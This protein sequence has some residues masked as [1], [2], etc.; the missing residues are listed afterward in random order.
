MD[1]EL[2]ALLSPG[3]RR[4]IELMEKY[5]FSMEELRAAHPE[6]SSEEIISASVEMMD[7]IEQFAAAPEDS[8]P[9]RKAKRKSKKAL[10]GDA[11]QIKITLRGSKPPIWRRVV[12]PVDIRL[13]KLHDVIQ[14]VMG[15]HNGHLHAFEIDGE[16]Y[17][18]RSLGAD[19]DEDSG[20][21]DESE[22]RLGELVSGAK[23][24]F[25]YVYDFGDDWDHTLAIEKLIPASDHPPMMTCLAKK[26]RGPLEDS[27]GLWGYYDKLRIMADPND[28]RHE[29]I[30]E[31][32]DAIDPTEFN[33]EAVNQRLAELK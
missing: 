20:A 7:V 30:A 33:L 2:A 22:F 4:I 9:A 24:K 17:Q 26:N 25:S 11:F 15:W 1:E 13:D 5:N 3:G 16:A 19:W 8:R 10:S 31:W 28:P 21:L 18:G 14:T 32:M 27:G 29:E 12:V 6:I 23:D